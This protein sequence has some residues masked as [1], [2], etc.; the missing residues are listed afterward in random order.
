[1]VPDELKND[2]SEFALIVQQKGKPQQV[3]VRYLTLLLN[4]RYGLDIIVVTKFVEAFSTIQKHRKRIRCAFVVQSRRIESKANIAPLNVE[5][6]IPLFLLLPK[7]LI[8]EHKTLCHRMANVQFCSWEN[9][10]SH[11]GSSLHKVVA[12]AFAEQGIGDLFAETE[13]LPPEDS[14]QLLEHR[15][16]KLRTL[17]TI[18]EVALRIMRIVEDPQTSIEELEDLLTHDPAIVH[19]LLQVVNS[20]TF[21]GTAKRESWPLQEA[22]VRLGRKQVGAIALQIKLMNSLVRP[23]ES[24]FDLRR[25]WRHSVGCAL[26]ADRLVKNQALTLPEPIPFDSYWIGALLHDIGKLVL[27]FFF[28]G[29]FEELIEKMR[30]EKLSFREAERAL[31]DFANHEFM[32]KIL[33]QRSKVGGNLVDAVGAHDTADGDPSPLVCLI[34]LANNISRTL[35]IGYLATEQ[36]V[37]S[38]QVLSALSIDQQKIDEMVE[39]LGEELIKEVDEMVEH[40]LGS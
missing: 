16:E 17:P 38:P 24:E 32:G 33:L 8:E 15:L 7:S 14:T 12:A 6:S 40:C 11:T 23:K 21:A 29:H 22:I 19:K 36:A 5:G 1:M 4:Y 30:S 18:P 27:G 31:G 9:A 34:H 28:W 2:D 25:F 13:A 37:Y 39:S 3:L 10:F 26:I 20:S 35:G